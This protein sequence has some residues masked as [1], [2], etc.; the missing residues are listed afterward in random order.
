MHMILRPLRDWIKFIWYHHK[1]CKRNPTLRLGYMSFVY[2]SV[3]GRNIILYD[4]VLVSDS[5]IGDYSYVGGQTKISNST[6]GKFCSLGQEIMIGGLP[7][8][9]LTLKSTYPGFYA[10]NSQY[11]RVEPEYAFDEPQHK[12]VTIGNDVW[13]GTRAMVLDGVS[14]GDGAIIGAGAVVTKDVPPYA[15]VAGVP[16]KIIRFRFSNEKINELLS[17]QWWND[18]KYS[19]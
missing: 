10:K 19:K 8:H 17:S 4:N 14:V 12:Q 6:L 1:T 9:P 3:L 18:P 7:C 16:A 13:I 11:Y 15:I 5:A 2:R